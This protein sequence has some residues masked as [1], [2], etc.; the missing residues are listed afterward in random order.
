[1][2]FE[3][4][5]N[6]LDRTAV[7]PVESRRRIEPDSVANIW[8]LL[9]GPLKM[10]TLRIGIAEKETLP[11]LPHGSGIDVD[12]YEAEDGSA[13]LEVSLSNSNYSDVF[14]VLLS[15]LVKAAAEVTTESQVGGAVAARIKHWQAFLKSKLD[16]LS[17]EAIRGLY[18][19]LKVLAW[20]GEHLNFEDAVACWVGPEG[21]PQDFQIHDTAVEVKTSA[22]KNPQIVLITSER[23]LDGRGL[24]ALFLWH[25]SVDERLNAGETLPTLIQAIRSKV[26]HSFVREVF[27]DRLLSVGYLDLHAERY[28]FGFAIRSSQ[29]FEVQGEFPR[30]VERDCPPGIGSV[31]YSLQLGAITPFAIDASALLERISVG[32]D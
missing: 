29:I 22:A 30:L 3:D 27:E 20:I 2:S 28:R 10:R 13:F 18:G 14:D 4:T 5:W 26:V 23:Q 9:K 31:S 32:H 11:D 7:S 1:M 15:D 24:T 16:G 12:F 21:Y 8:L 6:A 17:S 25:W 19:E